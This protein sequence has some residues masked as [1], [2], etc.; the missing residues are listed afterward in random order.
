MGEAVATALNKPASVNQWKLGLVWPDTLDLL[1]EFDG[2]RYRLQRRL[3]GPVYTAS[4]V[5]RFE[6]A[7]DGVVAAAVA[8]LKVIEGCGGGAGTVDLKE[9][10]HIIAV[11]CLGA[12][13]LGW[14]PGYIKSGSDGGTSKQ[15][16]MG[17]KRKSLFGLFPAVTKV[18]LLDSGMG[19]RVGKWL[20]RFWA[21]AWGVT[22][23]TPKGFKPFFTV[24]V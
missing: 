19:K 12:V 8:R 14:S 22:F 23:A 20:G 17:W 7:V 6:G 3:I 18:S 4:N 16:Y 15:S 2:K 24:C 10:M 11:E 21:D 9:W 5:K 13:V 1:S